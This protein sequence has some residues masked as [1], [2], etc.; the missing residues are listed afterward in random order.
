MTKRI[1]KTRNLDKIIQK[2]DRKRDQRERQ[3]ARERRRIEKHGAIV[4]MMFNLER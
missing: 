4:N 3:E 1:I 2:L